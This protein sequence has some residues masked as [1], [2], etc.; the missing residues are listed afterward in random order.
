MAYEQ[1]VT[2]YD[3]IY[4]ERA[5]NMENKTHTKQVRKLYSP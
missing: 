5:N 1:Q 4:N 3:K 2:I